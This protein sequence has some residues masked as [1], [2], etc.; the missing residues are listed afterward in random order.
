MPYVFGGATADD[1]TWDNAT[2]MGANNRA[3]FV[4]GWWK[5]TTLTA[6]RGLWS[7]GDTFGAEIDSTTDELRLRTDNTTDGQWTTTGVDLATNTWKFIAFLNTCTNTGPAAAWRVW[8]GGETSPPVEVTVTG[9]VS[10]SGNF[11]GNATGYVGNKGTGTLAFQGS[12]ENFVM[13]STASTRLFSLAAH[14]TISNDEA[15]ANYRNLVIPYWLG[16]HTTALRIAGGA[17]FGGQV[18]VRY[19]PLAGPLF[20]V[21]QGP[22]S[23]V[24]SPGIVPTVNGATVTQ[25]RS[26]RAVGS[27]LR[28]WVRR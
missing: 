4:C 24:T 9:A 1:I 12:V 10:P 8:A 27:S 25:E 13:M 28:P 17:E 11:V 2:T 18:N 3:C 6:T 16:D 20:N 26:P 22:T 7:A 23:A 19:V 14:G 21:V 5:P 15:A